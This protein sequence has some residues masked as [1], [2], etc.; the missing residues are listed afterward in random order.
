MSQIMVLTL[1]LKFR[2]FSLE[3]LTSDV[4]FGWKFWKFAFLIGIPSTTPGLKN[5]RFSE[6][7]TVDV[8]PTT[9]SDGIET[10]A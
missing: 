1:S 7:Q 4:N 2:L 3:I 6:F 9:W 5:V 10:G 8:V